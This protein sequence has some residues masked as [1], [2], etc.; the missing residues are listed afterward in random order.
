MMNKDEYIR[1]LDGIKAPEELKQRILENKNSSVAKTKKKKNKKLIAILA[2]AAAVVIVFT[3]VIG[4]FSESNRLFSKAE[5]F[6]GFTESGYSSSKSSYAA[7]DSAAENS[8][9]EESV[10]GSTPYSNKINVSER[11]VVKDASL[12]VQTKT[13][14]DFID[15]VNE[16]TKSLGG[17]SESINIRSYESG[18]AELTVR[19]PAEKLDEFIASIE[20]SATVKSKNISSEDITDSYTDVDSHIKALETEEKALLNIL[21]KC[22]TVK[23]TIEVQNRLSE[24]RSQLENYKSQKANMDSQVSY[25]KVT[26]SVSEE[27]RIIETDDSFSSRLKTKFEDSVYNIGHFF[28]NLAVNLLGG[29]LYILIIGAVATGIVLIYKK[30]RKKRN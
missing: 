10:S 23:D 13:L 2:S 21:E 12:Y 18:S 19:I 22:T 8:F 4:I 1:E 25:S 14:S 28:E 9:S 11:K 6:D 17:F 3:G 7:N 29:I 16:S 24:V 26:I 5:A 27:K 15:S 30:S 20:K